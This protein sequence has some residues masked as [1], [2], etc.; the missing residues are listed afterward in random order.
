MKLALHNEKAIRRGLVQGMLYGVF[1]GPMRKRD[2]IIQLDSESG[3]ISVAIPNP[4][5]KIKGY[6]YDEYDGDE[7][8]IN[9][10]SINS[11]TIESLMKGYKQLF[12]RDSPMRSISRFTVGFCLV[13]LAYYH[14]KATDV[15]A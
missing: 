10:K 8:P 13:W 6:Y 15:S 2:D 12:Q 5:N 9:M 3:I 4:D 7:G 11:S 1:I 14:P